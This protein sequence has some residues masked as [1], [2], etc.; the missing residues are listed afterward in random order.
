[1]MYGGGPAVA[2]IRTSGGWSV[3]S[4][5]VVVLTGLIVGS[6]IGEYLGEYAPVLTK[7]SVI[8]FGPDTFRFT[9]MLD[10]TLGFSLKINIVG[11]LG[12]IIALLLFRFIG[13]L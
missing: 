3:G 6:I 2:L 1:M 4:L 7:G 12:I 13:R 10:F 8:G 9:E 11:L 5:I